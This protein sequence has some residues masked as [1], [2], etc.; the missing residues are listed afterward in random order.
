MANPKAELLRYQHFFPDENILEFARSVAHD[1]QGDPFPLS[2]CLPG[3]RVGIA[4]RNYLCLLF[5]DTH[6]SLGRCVALGIMDQSASFALVGA[7][8]P[9]TRNFFSWRGKADEK[10][11]VER[12]AYIVALINEP[13]VISQSAAGTR[14]QRRAAHRGMG[15]AVD[16]WTRVS[17][18][19]SKSAVA[20]TARDP[21]FHNMPM[22]WRRGHFRRAEPHFKGAMQRPDAIRAEDRALWWQWIEGQWVGHPAFGVKKSV[23]APRLTG[24]G[25]ARRRDAFAKMAKDDK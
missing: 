24:T 22:H 12:F 19:I 9:G 5:N 8:A 1:T 13:R 11:I 20:K 2:S 16:A 4:V 18:D 25:V 15:F 23:H 21:G 17:W 7:W 3:E 14:Q 6:G 10:K